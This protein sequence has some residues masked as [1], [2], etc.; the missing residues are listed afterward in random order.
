MPTFDFSDIA[1]WGPRMYRHNQPDQIRLVG[2]ITLAM[3][4]GLFAGRRQAL[5]Q[6]L[7]DSSARASD[8]AVTENALPSSV[9]SANND[10]P[11]AAADTGEAITARS[12][13]DSSM[14]PASDN[15]GLE[16]P[17]S[18]GASEFA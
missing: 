12:I 17:P 5:A 8:T 2:L 3:L 18:D 9:K 1:D 11:D 13:N 10:T 14:H 7:D 4:L 16:Y 15:S 6:S